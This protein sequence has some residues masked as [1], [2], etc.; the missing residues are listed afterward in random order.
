M[1]L[2]CYFDLFVAIGDLDSFVSEQRKMM[3]EAGFDLWE[4]FDDDSEK[5]FKEWYERMHG[6]PYEGK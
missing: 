2:D 3:L 5:W 1:L 6:E 4:D